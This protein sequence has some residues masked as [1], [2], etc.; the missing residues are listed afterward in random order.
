MLFSIIIRTLNEEKYLQE[1]LTS[2]NSQIVDSNENT[3]IILVDSGSTDKTIEI[4]TT[5]SV[6]II[7]ISKDEFS[8]GRSLNI[9]CQNAKGEI[10]IFISGH[11]I[12]TDK[13]WLKNLVKPIQEKVASYTYGFQTGRDNTAFSEYQIFEKFFPDKEVNDLNLSFF[14]NNANAAL[15]KN[16]W[17]QFKFDET[18]T[19]LEDMK[20]AKILQENKK[21]IKYVRNAKVFHIHNE[22]FKQIKNRYEREALALKKILPEIKVSL[23]DFCKFLFLGISKDFAKAL[24]K[25]VL[26]KNLISIIRFR[27]FMNLGIYFGNKKQSISSKIDKKKYFFPNEEV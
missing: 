20:L 6:K 23:S 16:I 21:N 2:I 22:N 19:G 26:M 8:F 17:E 12:P 1:L 5:N 24:K 27:F 3:E 15:N 9:G 11:C 13:K 4:A 10:L 7:K 14:C 18:I 25:K